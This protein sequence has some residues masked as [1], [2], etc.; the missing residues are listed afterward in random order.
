MTTDSTNQAS[1]VKI[2]EYASGILLMTLDLPNK[3]A[4]ILND[5]LFRELDEAITP[6][7]ERDD[8]QG[9][10]M[11]SA[12]PKIFV[13]GA[14]LVKIAATLDWPDER[15]VKFCDDGR[16]IMSKFSLTPFPTVAAIHGACVGGGLELAM[17][18]DRRIAS[19]ERRTI[20]GL[21]EAK[22][23][24]VPGW[25]GTVR[26][27][28]ICALTNADAMHHQIDLVTSGRLL[29]ADQALEIGLVNEV[30]SQDALVEA[31]FKLLKSEFE[32]KEYFSDRKTIASPMIATFDTE[33][34]VADFGGDIIDNKNIYPFAP[35]VALEHML[36]AAGLPMKEACDSESIA[37][38][39]VYGSP[40]SY[41]LIN[42][43]FLGEHNKKNPGFVDPEIKTAP[44]TSVGI[45]GAGLMGRTIAA[46]NL[47]RRKTVRLLDTNQAV[48]ETVVAEL[49]DLS[50]EISV[51]KNHSEFA[52]CDLIIE[53][54][55]EN[56]Q[57]KQE[58]L[59]ELDNATSD[60]TVVATNTSAIPISTLAKA[61]KNPGRFC[62]IHFCHPELMS[63]VEVVRGPS[64]SGETIAKATSYVRSLGKMPVVVKDRAGFVVNRLLS[65]ML[66]Q[67]FR[68]FADGF[69]I[70]MIDEALCEFGFRGGPFEIVDTIGADTCLNAGRVMWDSG[71]TCVSDSLILPRMVKLGRLG[72]KTDRGFYTY[73]ENER[74]V[75]ADP[76]TIKQLLPYQTGEPKEY[77]PD[78]IAN[79]IMSAVTLAA[80]NLLE[81]G[82]VSDHRDI[83]LCIIHGFSFPAHHGGI[84][85]WADRFGIDN[86]VSELE[87][88]ASVEPRIKPN[89]RLRQMSQQGKTFYG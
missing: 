3:G 29:T 66:D 85:Y 68:L 22:L 87:K 24:L 7:L 33:Q 76:E 63:L 64:T 14:D 70:D 39:Q 6:L 54:A 20:L 67:S 26:V 82:I 28:R 43:F 62:G 80:S 27:A 36:R 55:T 38:S 61:I 57:V 60:S 12:K 19:D 65:A 11:F 89:D 83:D 17:W 86:V 34:L 37:M 69:S 72:R 48:A 78:P 18:C 84:L 56:E 21:P 9:L 40:A 71:L 44:I 16:A 52:D 5:K 79:S 58:I 47:R 31:A 75:V 30:A 49:A 35:T 23:G 46:N 25:G 41:G 15:I 13:A 81:E 73:V 88:I 74:S 42:N 32:S 77:A 4:N 2:S 50:N 51:A 1:S 53:S 59:K 10:I 45:I 8:I